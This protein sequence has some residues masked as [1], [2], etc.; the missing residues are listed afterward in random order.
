M[1]KPESSTISTDILL[2]LTSL[3]IEKWTNSLGIYLIASTLVVTAVLAA[4]AARASGTDLHWLWHDR[5][6]SCHGHAGDFARNSLNVSNDALQGRHH[7]RDFRQFLHHH[8]LGGHEVDA[9]YNMLLAQVKTQPRYRAEC[10]SCHGTAAEFV[11]SSLE[12]RDGTLYSRD[13]EHQVRLFL[14]HHRNLDPGDVEFFIN[15]LTRVAHEV[16]RP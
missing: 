14:D 12:L 4:A 9:I 15:V 10:S 6:A 11:R 8:Y 3:M 1:Q 7:T 2:R 16:Y 13:G 5:C